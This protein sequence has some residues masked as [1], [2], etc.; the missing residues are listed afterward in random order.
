[1]LQC[2]GLQR[3]GHNRVT[4]QQP[5]VLG[6][7]RPLLLQPLGQGLCSLALPSP[8]KVIAGGWIPGAASELPG[9]SRAPAFQSQ[10]ERQLGW[11]VL[12]RLLL[13]GNREEEWGGGSCVSGWGTHSRGE[14]PVR[15]GR[16]SQLTCRTN[17]E[18]VRREAPNSQRGDDPSALR[19]FW[20]CTEVLRGCTW[21]VS[22]QKRVWVSDILQNCSDTRV[23]ARHCQVTW[24]SSPSARSSNSGSH[25]RTT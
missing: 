18:D 10:T 14:G 25:S 1:M 4:E 23:T 21:V 7:S 11:T 19:L 17:M 16:S 22:R 5:L 3:V 6:L 2:M 15:I 9:Q 13:P 24:V 12:S 8:G 20:K